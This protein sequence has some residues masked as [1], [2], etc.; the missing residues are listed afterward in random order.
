MGA[1][2]GEG[3]VGPVFFVEAGLG[4]YRVPDGLEAAG[5]H[6][7]RHRTHLPQGA[8]DA[9]WIN[10]AA[11]RGWVA[12][13]KDRFHMR[14]GDRLEREAIH[15]SGLRV[16]V[17]RSANLTGDE[18]AKAFERALPRMKAM[19]A[20]HPGPFIARVHK[21]GRVTMWREGDGLLRP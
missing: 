15:A 16:F 21:D 20:A 9:D 17:L 5:A 12:L 8:P 11:K 3:S 7:E 10:L 2:E 19:A 4:A 14:K 6:V 13:T 1:A 18:M